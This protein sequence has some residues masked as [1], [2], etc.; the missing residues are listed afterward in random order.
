[1]ENKGFFLGL[2][3][4]GI[5]I[6]ALITRSS[7]ILLINIF[8]VLYLFAGIFRSPVKDEIKLTAIRTVKHSM[9]EGSSLSEVNV[10]IRN[11][12]NKNMF[13]IMK[14]P[15][16]KN[17]KIIEGNPRL[18]ACLVPNGEVELRYVF[19]A[20]RGGFKWDNILV[21]VMDPFGCIRKKLLI[22][23]KGD[24]FFHPQYRK[25]RP[26]ESYPWKTVSSPGINPTRRSGS[27]TDFFGIREYHPGDPIKKL[28]WKMTAKNPHKFFIREFEQESNSEIGIIVDGRKNMEINVRDASLFELEIS[29]AASLSEMFIRQGDRV[30]LSISGENHKSVLPGYGK[31]QLQKIMNVLALAE[32]GNDGVN[33][34]I[35][36]LPI[37]QYSCKAQLFFISPYDYNDLSYYRNLRSRGLQ[38]VLIS[39]DIMKFEHFNKDYKI[40]NDIALRISKLERRIN[41]EQVSQYAIP[42]V[43]WDIME[44]IQP[45]LKNVL[46][47][48]GRIRR[49]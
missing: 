16:F 12:G 46:R 29:L 23:A 32:T 3:I 39:P 27:S 40:E 7:E 17:M 43:D 6:L 36:S 2:G 13:L 25:F 11:N 24:S 19:N 48:A 20:A 9:Q 14:D 44:P 33:D 21:S 37:R 41:L 31:R 15:I 8:F 42:V 4:L 5:F 26:F 18:F 34:V 47:N 28:D 35:H 30:G 38:I 22:E 10:K 1:M 49:I 45:M